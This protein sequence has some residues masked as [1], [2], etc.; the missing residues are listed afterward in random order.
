MIHPFLR[1]TYNF[2]Q[3]NI[4]NILQKPQTRIIFITVYIF[5]SSTI[6][7]AS[8]DYREALQSIG[9]LNT[10]NHTITEQIYYSQAQAIQ[11]PRLMKSEF[12]TQAFQHKTTKSNTAQKTKT[13]KEQAKTIQSLEK[14]IRQNEIDLTAAQINNKNIHAQSEHYKNLAI[15][16]GV[17]TSLAVGLIVVD[18]VLKKK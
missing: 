4:M 9:S 3:R 13:I 1:H 15:L 10:T 11:A 6:T 17:T 12:V 8:F 16:G 5:F 14:I 2:N 18:R 7:I